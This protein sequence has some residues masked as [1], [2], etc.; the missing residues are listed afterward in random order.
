MVIGTDD[1][2]L[3]L[4][5]VEADVADLADNVIFV[6]ILHLT[7]NAPHFL[8]IFNTKC[9][10]NKISTTIAYFYQNILSTFLSI[11]LNIESFQRPK[12]WPTFVHA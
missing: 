3:S 7:L 12:E 10:L 1:Q 5:G 11:L 8:F 9:R 6:F 2:G 4:L